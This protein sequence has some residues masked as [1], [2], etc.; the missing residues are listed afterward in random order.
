MP[1]TAAADA[2]RLVRIP[3]Q[4]F[5]KSVTRVRNGRGATRTTTEYVLSN[6]TL[7][8]IPANNAVTCTCRSPV[9]ARSGV[10]VHDQ[11]FAVPL[12]TDCVEQVPVGAVIVN[13]AGLP[14]KHTRALSPT[15]VSAVTTCRPGAGAVGANR[16]P[17]ASET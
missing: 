3:S 6:S 4:L 14:L 1:A 12:A 9:P 5:K 10:T 15:F 16:V 2:A 13:A 11:W 7:P 8:G 17:F